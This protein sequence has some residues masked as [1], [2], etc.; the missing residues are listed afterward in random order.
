[1]IYGWITQYLSL[2]ARFK[3]LPM[4][5]STVWRKWRKIET[6]YSR[7]QDRIQIRDPIL[8]LLTVSFEILNTQPLQKSLALSTNYRPC[9]SLTVPYNV[10]I[11]T[12]PLKRTI[13][14]K[15]SVFGHLVTYIFKTIAG[16]CQMLLP[17]L[18]RLKIRWVWIFL[19]HWQ[20][21]TF[22][23]EY[24]VT[25]APVSSGIICR[26]IP[27]ILNIYVVV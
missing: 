23:L 7:S 5:W 8:D 15:E 27:V 10:L 4:H 14:L 18:L 2:L 9:N 25:A 6:P 17:N 13:L 24:H 1:M 11:W 19:L 16:I 26:P 20:H 12:V 21:I 3:V 22:Q